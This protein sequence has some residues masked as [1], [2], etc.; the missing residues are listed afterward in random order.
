MVLTYIVTEEVILSDWRDTVGG[1]ILK[2]ATLCGNIGVKTTIKEHVTKLTRSTV[3]SMLPRSRMSTVRIL[4]TNFCF[5]C[6][7]SEDNHVETAIAS[8]MKPP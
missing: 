4:F 6:N 5:F 1:T 7:Q 8:L 3:P 2:V